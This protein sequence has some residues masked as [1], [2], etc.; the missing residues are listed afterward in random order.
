MG[1]VVRRLPV[2]VDFG[3]ADVMLAGGCGRPPPQVGM[4]AHSVRTWRAVVGLAAALALG[5]VTRR[6]I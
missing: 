5:Q 1:R 2:W 4:A 6:I 3:G